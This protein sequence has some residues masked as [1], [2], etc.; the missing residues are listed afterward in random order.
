MRTV[1]KFP[2]QPAGDA[3]YFEAEVPA[4]AKPVLV[5]GQMGKSFI[6]FE[7]DTTAPK[8]RRLMCIVPTGGSIPVGATHVQSFLTNNG[9]YVWHVYE[10][11]K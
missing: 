2:I 6:W 8:V 4:D 1:H 10:I 9:A 3:A 5:A 7:L 11:A